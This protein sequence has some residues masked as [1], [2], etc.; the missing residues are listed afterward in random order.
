MRKSQEERLKDIEE[1]VSELYED[2]KNRRKK[3]KFGISDF[4]QQ[5]IGALII[6]LPFALTEEIWNLA[7][8]LSFPRIIIIF[9]IITV[10]IYLFIKHSKL[11]NWESQEVMHFVPLRLITSISI[12]VI[13]SFISLTLLGVYPDVINN[14]E[15]LI[16]ATL[17][18]S[19]FAVIGSLGVDMAK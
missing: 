13:V 11:Q 1:K 5:L 3:Q 2:Y 18:V 16:K 15:T 4:I 14:F 7:Q 9:G 17:L 19:V 10:F 8:K 6:A 12:S